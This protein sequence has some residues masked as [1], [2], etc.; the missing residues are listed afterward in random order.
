MMA[1]AAIRENPRSDQ[2]QRDF[3]LDGA[4]RPADMYRDGAE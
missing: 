1:L 3:A 4:T 2:A